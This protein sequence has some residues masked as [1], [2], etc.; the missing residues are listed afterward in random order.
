MMPFAAP[1]ITIH[2][3]DGTPPAKYGNRHPQFAPLGCFRCAGEDNW[4]A[5]AVTNE[6]MWQRLAILIGRADW[7]MDV[8]L[9]SAEARRG[10]EE[11]IER[12]VDAWNVTREADQAMSEL[13]AAG[14][15]AGVA[16]LPID[17]IKDQHLRSRRY[18]REIER[19]FIGLHLQPSMPIREGEGPYAIRTAAP[20]LGKH[21]REILSALLGLSDADIAQLVRGTSL[22]QQ[23]SPKRT[24]PWQRRYFQTD[25]DQ[26]E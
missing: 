26:R 7:S 22:G 5:V 4:I 2:S 11:W 1:W 19:T 6:I 15:A 9:K 24:S 12:G 13:Q 25:S 3:I 18:L 17:L 16:R 20:T 14:V 21:N 10:I 8:S 23:Y